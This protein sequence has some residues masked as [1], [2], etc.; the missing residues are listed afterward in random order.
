MR[1][2]EFLSVLGGGAAAA[3]P[4][5]LRAQQAARIRRI[6][7]LLYTKQEQANISPMLRGLEALGYVEGKNVAI[8]YRDADGKFERLS[9]AADELVRLKPDL[10][11][12][13]RKQ[14]TTIPIVVVVSN[15]PVESGIVASL[16]RPGGNITGV[17]WIHDQLAGKAVE[18]L[19]E[20]VPSVFR[21][22]VL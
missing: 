5:P 8:E 18:L 19:K 21:V 11:F 16:G 22:A 6:G 3:W 14:T 4:H 10:I 2:R 17:T 9:A 13:S 7:I 15:D 1:R 20:T 12:S